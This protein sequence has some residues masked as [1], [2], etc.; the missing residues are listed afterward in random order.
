VPQAPD[1]TYNLGAQLELPMGNDMN[2]YARVDLQHVG[3]T[4]FHTLQGEA[5]PNIWDGL[6]GTG[7]LITTDFSK[8]RR[9]AYDT[10]NLRIGFEAEN[11]SATIWGRNITDEEYLEEVIPAVEFGGSFI[12]PAATATYGADFSFRF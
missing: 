6:F 10:V 3:E 2:F 12:H 5:T 11:W 7:G 8:T 4:W 1:E 9:D